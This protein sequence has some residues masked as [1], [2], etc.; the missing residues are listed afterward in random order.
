MA[1]K[2]K[3][4][5]DIKEERKYQDIKWGLEFD[6]K[7]TANDW[8][9]YINTYASNASVMPTGSEEYRKLMIKVAALA[10]AAIELHDDKLMPKRHYEE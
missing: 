8:A 10:V 5:D 4:L 1:D 7:N 6:K 3:I 9:T 2:Q